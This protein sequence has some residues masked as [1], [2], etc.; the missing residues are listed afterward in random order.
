MLEVS[1]ISRLPKEIWLL[2]LQEWLIDLIDVSSLDVA[3]LSNVGRS[4]F[5]DVLQHFTIG[6][7]HFDDIV[8]LRGQYASIKCLIA[9]INSRKMQF[10]ELQLCGSASDD[11]LD[12][13]TYSLQSITFV[14]LNCVR[15]HIELSLFSIMSKIQHVRTL[16]VEECD[17]HPAP[18]DDLKNLSM[19]LESLT[20]KEASESSM[21]KQA[22]FISSLR[23]T[24]THLELWTSLSLI[25]LD[26]LYSCTKLKSITLP[27]DEGSIEMNDWIATLKHLSALESI[28]FLGLPVQFVEADFLE[29]L[30]PNFAE[31]R[32]VKLPYDAKLSFSRFFR[33]IKSLPM[34]EKIGA[35]SFFF[36]KER[37]FAVDSLEGDDEMQVFLSELPTLSGYDIYFGSVFPISISMDN[38]IALSQLAGRNVASLAISIKDFVD[39][40]ALKENC[41]LFP[42]LRSFSLYATDS[43]YPLGCIEYILES[44][45][46]L[47]VLSTVDYSGTADKGAMV[48]AICSY[49]RNLTELMVQC[50]FSL[51]VHDLEKLLTSCK[52]LSSLS[53][54]FDSITMIESVHFLVEQIRCYRLQKLI[55]DTR[56]KSAVM[57][58]LKE[59][60]NPWNRSLLKRICFVG[61]SAM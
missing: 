25:T 14:H 15:E 2:I 6:K 3:N 30:L 38:F 42:R 23:G 50:A 33:I 59:D 9:W 41:C 13:S 27:I 8:K 17:K 5:L 12:L 34:I 24:L 49:G 28:E 19:P 60:D 56:W 1:A 16:E 36:S 58:L 53:L 45:P 48:D 57:K 35:Q 47:T 26:A 11:F 51:T 39:N 52:Q 31:I 21:N 40:G 32:I 61:F 46:T 4:Y 43:V 37:G 55:I 44:C 54:L 29:Q 22:I 7:P 10:S 18:W 20:V